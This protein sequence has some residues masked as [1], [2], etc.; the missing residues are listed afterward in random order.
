MKKYVLHLL[1][2]LLTTTLFGQAESEYYFQGKD[3][4][5]YS[6]ALKENRKITIS[7]PVTFTKEKATKFPVIIVFDSQNKRIYRQTY[8]T[9]NYLESAKFTFIFRKKFYLSRKYAV[10]KFAT[11]CSRKTLYASLKNPNK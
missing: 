8:E 9:I 4:I 7:L 1:F 11:S 6:N 2:V 10:P 5:I 3:T